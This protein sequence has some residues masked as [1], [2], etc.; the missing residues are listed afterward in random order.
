M[1]IDKDYGLV[2]CSY[3]LKI[4][5]ELNRKTGRKKRSK[6]SRGTQKR[7]YTRKVELGCKRK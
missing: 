3:E 4:I 1:K 2:S 6:S 7:K 5:A